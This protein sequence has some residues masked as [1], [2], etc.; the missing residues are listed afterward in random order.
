MMRVVAGAR[1]DDPARPLAVRQPRHAVV[2]AADLEAECRLQILAL[3]QHD[4][5]EARRQ[6]RRLVE[7]RFARHLVHTAR[8][9]VPDQ[10]ID[11]RDVT[12]ADGAWP[13]TPST[14]PRP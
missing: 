8:E 13:D 9:D 14:R 12:T 2:G 3:Q 11:H 7:R 5:A 4:V 1:R 10:A 6:A